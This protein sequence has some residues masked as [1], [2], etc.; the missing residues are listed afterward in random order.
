M[1]AAHL[2]TWYNIFSDAN[3]G[4]SGISADIVR[5]VKDG[6]GIHPDYFFDDYEGEADHRVYL[7][8]RYRRQRAFHDVQD[9]V[10]RHS[11][12][13]EQIQAGLAEKDAVIHK[14]AAQIAKMKHDLQLK[15][16]ARP[17]LL[18]AGPGADSVDDD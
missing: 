6:L 10:A 17:R 16:R 14:Q 11:V 1:S 18:K 12:L 9:E 2:S 5:R 3:G 15:D 7:L 13:L 4:R 8:D